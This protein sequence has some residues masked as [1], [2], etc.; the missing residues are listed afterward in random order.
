MQIFDITLFGIHIAPS[1]YW[2][3]YVIWFLGWYLIIKKRN[4]FNDEN[5]KSFLNIEM[6]DDL[7]FYIFLW[8]ILWWRFWYVLFYNPVYYFN[9]IFDILKIWQWWM[10]FHGWVIWVIIAMIFFSRKYKLN[11]YK[12]A[13]EITAILPIW[14]WFGRI[15]NYLNK[16]LLGFSNYY[17]PLNI[18]W[19][20]P[21]PLVE[22]VLEWLV[23]YV[24][25]NYIYKKKQFDW[26]IATLFLILYWIFRIFVEILFR[27][28]DI[29]IW[30]LY[31]YFTM[32]EIL[33]IPM[34]IFWI[35]YYFKLWK[36][37]KN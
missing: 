36:C 23:L 14:L 33:T 12:L 2:L 19:R 6:L 35:Y 5:K 21:S 18:N 29:N 16:E 20:F 3:M 8:V 27:E 1:Y 28:P 22:V 11:F 24:I 17:W 31:W 26:Q 7:L 25:L 9:N 13:D 4:V 10:S 30:Y 34:I 15:W 32:W 37:I